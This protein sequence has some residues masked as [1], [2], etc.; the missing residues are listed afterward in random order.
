MR[1]F[2]KDIS[3]DINDN[4]PFDLQIPPCKAQRKSCI[5]V[6]DKES[7]GTTV[8]DSTTVGEDKETVAENISQE[9]RESMTSLA[10][11]VT[12]SPANPEASDI[13][14]EPIKDSQASEEVVND[15]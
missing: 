15:L 10:K 8:L 2:A 13:E 7:C 6:W 14:S 3:F 9:V 12:N 4:K 5:L 11:E 1:C